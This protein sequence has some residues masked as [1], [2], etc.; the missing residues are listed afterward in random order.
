MKLIGTMALA[1]VVLGAGGAVAQ[2][3]NGAAKIGRGDYRAAERELVAARAAH[4][5]DVELTLNLAAV[6]ARTG[7]PQ[8]ARTA[9]RQAAAMPDEEVILANGTAVSSRLLAARA[10]A[11]VP[12]TLAAN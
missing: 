11:A 3:F 6:Y 12:A 8:L 2:P 9:Y 4:P 5:A 10:M 7:R 1:A